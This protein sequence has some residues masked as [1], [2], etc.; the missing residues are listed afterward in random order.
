MR[1]DLTDLK[2]EGHRLLDEYKSVAKVNSDQAYAALK[3]KM[4]DRAYHFWSMND[5]Q[6]VKLAIGYLKKMIAAKKH[7]NAKSGR[8]R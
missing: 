4:K 8:S 3:A 6:T 1:Y 5:P 2:A 7:E